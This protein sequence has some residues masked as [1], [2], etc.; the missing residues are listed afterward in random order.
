MPLVSVVTPS[1]NQGRFIE[2]TITSVLKQTYPHIDYVVID[3]GSTDNTLKLLEKYRDR[4]RYV[5]EP[6]RGQSDAINKGWRMARGEILAWLNS[7]DTYLPHTIETAVR[8]LNEHPDAGMVCGV[9]RDVDEKADFLRLEPSIEHDIEDILYGRKIWTI[10]QP[11]AFVRKSVLDEVGLLDEGLHYGMDW[12]LWYRIAFRYRILYTDHVLANFR[13]WSGQ[14]TTLMRTEG[15]HGRMRDRDHAR[16][17]RRYLG[18]LRYYSWLLGK[19][20]RGG[21]RRLRDGILWITTP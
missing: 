6:D 17:Q 13:V 19:R 3:G 9:C 20:V 11:A 7:D 18:T 8:L 10:A 16:V 2:E 4:L 21:V 5:S 1:F 14:K 15:E 12:D